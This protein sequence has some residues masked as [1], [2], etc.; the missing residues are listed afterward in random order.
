M[1]L[2]IITAEDA[3]AN[4]KAVAANAEEHPSAIAS[5][6]IAAPGAKKSPDVTADDMYSKVLKLVPAPLAGAYAATVGLVISAS[7]VGASTQ[8]AI[9]W[10]LF[11]FFIAAVA[12][13]LYVRK[14]DRPSQYLL[15]LL[16]F[17]S[18]ATVTPGPFTR[19]SWWSD[20]YGSIAVILAGT[21]LVV[22]QPDNLKSTK[23]PKRTAEELEAKV[24]EQSGK[25]AELRKE[26]RE[27]KAAQPLER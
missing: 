25:I 26:I 3:K 5:P 10:I 4:I 9:M 20:A 24:H 23:H 6:G 19:M 12:A 15:T 18:V 11:A 17:V 2:N 1:D 22:F 16:A 14:I 7:D 8:K 21:F 27:L 13:Y